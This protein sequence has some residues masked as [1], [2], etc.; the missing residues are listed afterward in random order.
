[1]SRVARQAGW[2]F[3]A[4]MGMGLMGVSLAVTSSVNVTVTDPNEKPL[5]IQTLTLTPQGG[6]E[7]VTVENDDDDNK[8][9]GLVLEGGQSYEVTAVDQDGKEHRGIL[10][11]PAGG[12]THDLTLAMEAIPAGE[13]AGGGNG[14]AA[15]WWQRRSGAEKAGIAA[16]AVGGVVLLANSGNGDNNGGNG[17]SGG[18]APQTGGGTQPATTKTNVNVNCTAINNPQGSATFVFNELLHL[19]ILIINPDAGA[20]A[21]A[22]IVMNS[23]FVLTGT[24]QGS[25]LNASGHGQLTGVNTTVSFN[26]TF[27]VDTGAL[28][29]NLQAGPPLGGG[30]SDQVGATCSGA[31]T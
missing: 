9:A 22:R 19:W 25:Q 27:D 10:V 6:G 17:G 20:S 23:G 12:G 21:S 3:I 26:G 13:T 2:F 31:G 30:S 28:Q 8:V 14:G 5:K 29:G 11:V 4:T 7:A 1:M 18:S 16:A 15:G 24:L